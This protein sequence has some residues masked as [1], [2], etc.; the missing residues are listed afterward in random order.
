MSLP[1]HSD[2]AGITTAPA[3]QTWNFEIPTVKTGGTK[4]D[5]GA[6][7]LCLITNWFINGE[8]VLIDGGVSVLL[9]HGSP[10]R[11]RTFVDTTKTPV[12]LLKKNRSRISLSKTGNYHFTKGQNLYYMYMYH[13]TQWLNKYGELFEFI[14]LKSTCN[15]MYE[16][17]AAVV[18]KVYEWMV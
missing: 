3:G 8:T 1:G 12:V 10:I 11:W 9:V 5:V 18:G 16:Y 2:E 14:S 17:K 6:L 15:M 4:R 13:S 7:A